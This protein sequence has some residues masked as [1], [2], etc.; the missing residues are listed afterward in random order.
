MFRRAGLILGVMLLLWMTVDG[1][2]SKFSVSVSSPNERVRIDFIL[3][4]GNPY[5]DV[6][7]KDEPIILDS[8]LGF[9]F[10]A[11]KPL[12]KCFRIVNVIRNSAD[13]I[14]NLFG[15]REAR[16]ETITTN[17]SLSSKRRR[18]PTDR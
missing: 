17:S 5:Y 13:H 2:V 9:H 8:S 12:N 4:N 6:F 11:L 7:Y 1:A 16:S 18:H 14:W 10:E 3:E 15:E